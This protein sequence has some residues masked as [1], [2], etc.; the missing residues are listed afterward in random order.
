M[1]ELIQELDEDFEGMQ[2]T[3]V[4]LQQQL[5]DKNSKDQNQDQDQQSPSPINSDCNETATTIVGNNDDRKRI[6][7]SASELCSQCKVKVNDSDNITN[8]KKAKL[9]CF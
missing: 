4:Y 9:S 2:S 5:R 3:I 8:M 1:A 7:V 6:L